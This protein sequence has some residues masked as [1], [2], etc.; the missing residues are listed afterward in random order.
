MDHGSLLRYTTYSDFFDR[1]QSL[2][3]YHLRFA[4]WKDRSG[5][6]LCSHCYPREIAFPP[7]DNCRSPF[8]STTSFREITCWSYTIPHLAVMATSSK[9]F[10]SLATTKYKGVQ[11]DLFEGH[12]HDFKGN[13][14]AISIPANNMI[15]SKRFSAEYIRARKH[16]ITITQRAF[17]A[18]GDA[19]GEGDLSIEVKKGITTPLED[20]EGS[21]KVTRAYGL[22]PGVKKIIHVYHPKFISTDDPDYLPTR[23]EF[24][25]DTYT[26][27]FD[28]AYE[29]ENYVPG[30]KLAISPLSTELQAWRSPQVCYTD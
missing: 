9:D 24:L 27:A 6:S 14:I 13:F 16:K 5:I 12:I 4:C 29:D 30:M 10:R 8:Q 22:E 25:W 3:S 19:N 17:E 1:H 20:R 23:F 18:A 21:V 2:P 28:A 11:V 26:N 15:F 7:Q